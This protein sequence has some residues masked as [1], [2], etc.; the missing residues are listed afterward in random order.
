M[1]LLIR[2]LVLKRIHYAS[3]P[4]PLIATMLLF[5]FFIP[6]S[7]IAINNS[8]LYTLDY[9]KKAA[10]FIIMSLKFTPQHLSKLALTIL[11]YFIFVITFKFLSLCRARTVAKIFVLSGLTMALFGI[12][13][14]ISPSFMEA[15]RSFLVPK[16]L[17]ITEEFTKTIRHL[18]IIH[19]VH[20]LMYEAGA[21]AEYLL[22][23]IFFLLANLSL[24]N[25]IFKKSVDR[26][27]LITILFATMLTGSTTIVVAMVAFPLILFNTPLLTSKKKMLN[28]WFKGAI[29]ILIIIL[30]V[31]ALSFISP[32][33]LSFYNWTMTKLQRLQEMENAGGREGGTVEILKIIPTSPLLGLGFGSLGT[34]E[35]NIHAGALLILLVNVGIIGTVLYLLYFLFIFK[36]TIKILNSDDAKIHPERVGFF[37][38][39]I[40]T[41]IIHLLGRGFLILAAVN[42]WFLAAACLAQFTPPFLGNNRGFK[43]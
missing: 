3:L 2:K 25:I 39:F 13:D 41:L 35:T 4:K 21:L 26:L 14:V 34:E 30:A 5:L 33:A 11:G 8:A 6:I 28:I 27:I 12:L 32:H 1:Y 36:E 19:R 31:W 22:G 18:G 24:N 42:L 38:S 16:N 7:W 23:V 20:G 40:L 10:R 15:V 37:W 29:I 43:F 9:D 17:S